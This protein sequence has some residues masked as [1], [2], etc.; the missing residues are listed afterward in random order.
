MVMQCLTVKDFFSFS[1]SELLV[2]KPVNT[3]IFY[4]LFFCIADYFKF[5]LSVQV[6]NISLVISQLIHT[7]IFSVD[8][9]IVVFS[10]VCT[11]QCR[12]GGRCVRPDKCK[13]PRG[14][15]ARDCSK[16]KFVPSFTLISHCL[17][18][19]RRTYY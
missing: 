16:R 9:M 7:I 11:L 3:S 19:N 4:Q 5:H 18:L 12:N 1:F 6:G 13:C 2:Y 10:A 15:S 8:R 14:Y 17:A